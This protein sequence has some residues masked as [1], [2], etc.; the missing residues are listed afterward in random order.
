[1][2]TLV[3]RERP[4]K[5]FRITPITGLL[6]PTAAMATVRSVLEKFPTIAI[7]DALNSCSRIPVAATGRA[8]RGILFQIEPFRISSFA[9]CFFDFIKNTSL[10]LVK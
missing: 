6:A 10:I 7:S 8:Y 3:P 9:V 2:T 5:R 1:M 4:M